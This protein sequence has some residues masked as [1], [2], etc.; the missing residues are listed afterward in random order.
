MD[1]GFDIRANYFPEDDQRRRKLWKKTVQ[2]T[3]LRGTG[4]L[5]INV[6]HTSV[7]QAEQIARAVAFILT[8]RASEFISGGGVA[9][10]LVDDPLNSRYP[11]KPNIPVNAFTGLVLGAFA[12]VGVLLVNS[13]RLRRRHQ[14][15][16]EEW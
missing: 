2:P 3:V 1:S 11:V 4:L 10:R 8:T 13:E 15:I 14:L 7:G 12:G 6:Y 9:A 5:E 16:H